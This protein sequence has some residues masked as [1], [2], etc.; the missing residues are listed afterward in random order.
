MA[1]E[2]TENPFDAI[3]G[4]EEPENYRKRVSNASGART[5]LNRAEDLFCRI[6]CG[7]AGFNLGGLDDHIDTL[8]EEQKAVFLDWRFRAF[9]A[10]ANTTRAD[11]P[12]PLLD[13]WK[14]AFYGWLSAL[15]V[16]WK[17]GEAF[18]IT[19]PMAEHGQRFGRGRAPGAIDKAVD[20]YIRRGFKTHPGKTAT[21]LYHM[22]NKNLLGGMT[23]KTFQNRVSLIRK[24]S[25]D[26]LPKPVRS[27]R[28][29]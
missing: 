19:L 14:E 12:S 17:G 6:G 16:N 2:A 3:D 28:K 11:D 29:R 8:P 24:E 9:I 5:Y 7:L 22:A 23:L 27:S 21:Q 25:K 15:L 26:P 4:T 18:A 1:A 20:T 13:A 10:Y